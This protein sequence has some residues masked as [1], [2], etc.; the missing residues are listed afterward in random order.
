M[1]YAQYYVTP[2][3]WVKS[4]YHALHIA[5]KA[6]V[7]FKFL[8]ILNADTESVDTTNVGTEQHKYSSPFSEKLMIYYARVY[9][10]YRYT[11]EMLDHCGASL[12]EQY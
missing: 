6:Y 12:S 3:V 10:M 9:Y 11:R 1:D 2:A 7:R 4:S 5:Q 8:L